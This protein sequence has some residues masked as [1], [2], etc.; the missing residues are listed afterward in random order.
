A[1]AAQQLTLYGESAARQRLVSLSSRPNI[2]LAR[3]HDRQLTAPAAPP[4]RTGPLTTSSRSV[5]ELFAGAG[6]LGLGFLLA[7]RQA[8]HYRILCSAEVE[9]IYVQTLRQNHRYY[10]EHL[11]ASPGQVPEDLQPLDLRSRS[12]QRRLS[13]LVKA[14]GG[15]DIIIGGPPCQG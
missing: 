9:P 14:A 15:L 6:G 8:Q 5:L 1:V 4:S 11:A 2:R 12:T 10:K 13:A 3:H 7:R